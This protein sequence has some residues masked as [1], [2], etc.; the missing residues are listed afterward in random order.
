MA[1]GVA[2][3]SSCSKDDDNGGNDGGT[4]TCRVNTIAL[5]ALGETSTS[6]VTYDAN[7]RPVEINTVQGSDVSGSKLSYDANGNVTLIEEYSDASKTIDYK[8][9]YTYTDGKV[10]EVK[11]YYDNGGTLEL[12][13]IRRYE[14][15][16]SEVS[17][18]KLFTM[19]A[20][21]EVEY[22]YITYTYTNGSVTGMDQYEDD[23][24]GGSTHVARRAIT[25]D[26]HALN[27]KFF[28]NFLFEDPN[29]PAA[30]YPVR[31]KQEYWDPDN[32][33]WE[34]DEDIDYVYTW[35][36]DNLPATVT[37]YQGLAVA[38]FSYTCE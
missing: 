31:D 16:G 12:D 18:I 27:Y 3:I 30:N 29:F 21:Q 7:K 24:Q 10:S 15:S 13:E 38:T 19:D 36:S 9:E 33:V 23:G 28:L 22:G 4:K 34:I 25:Y 32:S 2:F 1:M 11:I 37:L 14:Y 6:S 35:N 5:N 8:E 17:K 20:G 26:T